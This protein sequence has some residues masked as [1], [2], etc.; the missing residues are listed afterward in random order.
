MDKHNLPLNKLYLA[1]IA[2]CIVAILILCI[3][4]SKNNV[5]DDIYDYYVKINWVEFLNNCKNELNLILAQQNKAK[6]LIELF[7][8]A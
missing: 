2:V 5:A 8:G 3:D 7:L 6:E 4:F 1:V